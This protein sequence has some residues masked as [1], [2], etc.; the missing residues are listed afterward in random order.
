MTLAGSLNLGGGSLGP[1]SIIH[2]SS[3]GAASSAGLNVRAHDILV[4]DGSSIST[5]TVSTGAAGPL[6]IAADSLQLIN[7]GRI[8]SS[9][10]QGIDVNT[11]LPG[12]PPPEGPAGSV[13]IQGL[14][15]PAQ[16]VLIDGKDSGVF[17]STVG[18]GAGGN[19][20]ILANTLTL[21]NG[22]TLSAATSGIAP[23]ATGGTIT[24]DANEVQ[25]NSGGLITAATTGAGVGGSVNINAGNTFSSNAGTVS[26]TASQANGGNINITAGQTVTLTNGAIVSASS[27]GPGNAGNIFVDAGPQLSMQDS[28]ITSEAAK[29]HGG[30]IEIRA[31]DMVQ[32]GNS[33]VSTSVIGG[34]GGGGNITID[35]NAVVLQNSQIITRA[36]QG[37]GGNI[38]IT[39]NLLL[40]DS[41]SIIS[42]SSQFGQQGNIVIQS[43]ISPASGKIVPLGQKPLLATTLLG[44]RCAALAGG[45]ISSFTVAGR[46]ALPAEPGGWVST[47]LALSM[48]ESDDGTVNEAS[49]NRTS[50]E[51]A[52]EIPVLSLRK[53]APPGFLT[54][55]FAVDSSDCQS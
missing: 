17:T 2:A 20:N 18:T 47:P 7:G 54:Q 4:T 41:T 10:R 31:V 27:T 29:A 13:T 19:I 6:S 26:S 30:N 14:S 32:L 15:S 38:S 12:G 45:N 37:A 34:A 50:S 51:V 40:Q 48:S 43:P 28:S 52:E 16:S 44:Q 1:V 49:L 42:A 55:S 39:T 22:G 33:T 25:V 3:V 5:D 21:Q 23:S 35:P 8:S 36:V 24:V 46:D 11:G 9:S 53:I